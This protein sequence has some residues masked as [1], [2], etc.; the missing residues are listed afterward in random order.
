MFYVH[1][2]Q[3]N[4]YGIFDT[5]DL[6]LEWLSYSD[7]MRAIA[8]GIEVNGVHGSEVDVYDYRKLMC[9]KLCLL[10]EMDFKLNDHGYIE[11]LN[12]NRDCTIRLGDLATGVYILA[13]SA[14][15]PTARHNITFVLDD[16]IK[17]F[18]MQAMLCDNGYVHS[19]DVRACTSLDMVMN[20]YKMDL[21]NLSGGICIIDDP[22]RYAYAKQECNILYGND[23][24][25]LGGIFLD[26]DL[27]LT[28]NKENLLSLKKPQCDLPSYHELM[29]YTLKEVC[30]LCTDAWRLRGL[31][32]YLVMGGK[33]RELIA[34]YEAFAGT[35]KTN[36]AKASLLY[37]LEAKY[38]QTNMLRKILACNAG[39]RIAASD[40]CYGL[41]LV[42]SAKLDNVTFVLDDSLTEFHTWVSGVFFDVSAV[43][44]PEL[45]KQIYKISTV[46]WGVIIDKPK[47]YGRF[48]A[49]LLIMNDYPYKGDNF[50][51][52]W[53]ME[54]HWA[55]FRDVLTGIE[56]HPYSGMNFIDR[57][58][59]LEFNDKDWATVE[60]LVPAEFN[61]SHKLLVYLM[62]GGRDPRMLELWNSIL[63]RC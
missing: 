7:V 23:E 13:S 36:R 61:A 58:R 45:L 33:D 60:H 62:S 24:I 29:G 16:R 37:G 41:D 57:F 42:E 22:D 48:G 44:K 10:Y 18:T 1:D 26:E 25:T 56:V 47:R 14:L 53:F 51:D 17:S 46:L 20:V 19:Y 59:R 15:C 5:E 27:F 6:T 21:L 28:R 11:I 8:L 49:E 34:K 2:I 4:M 50:D 9:S 55:L 39:S 35:Y 31:I 12:I 3:S 63:D 38:S 52:E 54:R 43:T 40:I 32:R 30:H